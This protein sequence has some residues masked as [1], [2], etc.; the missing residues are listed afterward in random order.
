MSQ[1]K[2]TRKLINENDLISPLEENKEQYAEIQDNS[3]LL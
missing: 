3:V 1:Y 2:Q